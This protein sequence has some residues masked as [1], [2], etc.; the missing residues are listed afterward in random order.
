[1][2]KI[3]FTAF[4][5]LSIL[6]SKAQDTIRPANLPLRSVLFQNFH[7]LV[8]AAGTYSLEGEGYFVTVQQINQAP[9]EEHM[10]ALIKSYYPAKNDLMQKLGMNRGI[11][12]KGLVP[13]RELKDFID[14]GLSLPNKCLQLVETYADGTVSTSLYYYVPSKTGN[15]FQLIKTH[16]TLSSIITIN[17]TNCVLGF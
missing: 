10:N 11:I 12:K 7:E 17:V 15:I 4:A 2:H 8:N 6:S 9:T 1:M 14:A 3:L 16:G 13:A 5:F